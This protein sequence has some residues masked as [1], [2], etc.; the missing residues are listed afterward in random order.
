MTTKLMK[1]ARLHEVGGRFQ[2]DQIPIP[3]VRPNDV[4]IKVAATGMV[5]NLRNVITTYPSQRPYLPLPRLPAI[6]GLDATG[7]VSAVGSLVK[8]GIS[9]GDRVYVNPGLSCGSCEACRRGDPTNCPNYTFMGYFGFGP[10]SQDQFEAYPY[11]GFGEYLTCPV[12]NLVKLPDTL[13]FEHA[14]RFGYLGTS[15]AALK[16]A[17]FA[18]GQTLLVNGGTG[19]LGVGT[20]LL[21]L[22]MG[23]ARIFATG[24]DVQRL[25]KLQALDLHRIQLLP[26]G[27]G[28][29]APRVLAQT[30]DLGV[31]VM[32]DALA[33]GAPISS[34]EDAF[35]ALRFGGIAVNVGGVAD[36][37]SIQFNRLMHSQR[38]LMGSR[39]FSTSEAQ[40]MAN[41]TGAGT[42]K[43]DAFENLVYPLER[44]ND[45]LHD[46]DSRDG[47]F[48]NVVISP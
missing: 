12:T 39:W 13:S 3:D 18:P 43:L 38:V 33:P 30:A 29:V 48:T 35:Q 11:G 6:F 14:S 4:L 22:A 47:G 8:S 20:V 16:K 36:K 40:D 34:V 26:L 25:K 10:K 5:H 42:L 44:I 24:R 17:R 1:A 32:I 15:Y 37:F 7:V 2:I 21:A 19:T 27:E 9:V 31:D 23:A 28:A 41:M 45:A 46:V